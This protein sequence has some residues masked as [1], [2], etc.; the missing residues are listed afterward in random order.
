MS[1]QQER[2]ITDQQQTIRRLQHQLQDCRG[3]EVGSLLTVIGDIREC[4]GLGHK[5][6]L[7]DLPKLIG[8]MRNQINGY[9]YGCDRA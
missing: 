5:P 9:E 2:I 6:M 4:S 7:A 3:E 8:S 1:K